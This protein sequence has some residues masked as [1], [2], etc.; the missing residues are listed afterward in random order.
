MF[1]SFLSHEV[2]LAI[3]FVVSNDA[4]VKIRDDP[5]SAELE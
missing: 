4:G 5:L 3:R 2:E 1:L